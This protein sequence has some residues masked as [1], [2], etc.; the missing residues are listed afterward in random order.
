MEFANYKKYKWFYTSTSKLVVGGKSASQND[1]LLK[2][3]KKKQKSDLL[4]MHTASP[5]SPFAI[6]VSNV[7]SISKDDKEETATFTA[8]FSQAWKKKAKKVKVHSFLLSN[9]SKPLKNK[10]GSWDVKEVEEEFEVNLELSLIKQDG[11]LRAVPSKTA[12]NQNIFLKLT[13]GSTEKKD[14]LPK[15]AI[16]LDTNK[17]SEAELLQALPAGGINIKTK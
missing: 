2:E 1:E 10:T 6:I 5:G 12:K 15:I 16:L 11:T 9:L 3:I 14:L 7:K 13:P 4:V 17:V 8:C